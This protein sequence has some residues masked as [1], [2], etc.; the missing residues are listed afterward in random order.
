MLHHQGGLHVSKLGA[1]RRTGWKRDTNLS[2]V[3]VNEH[4]VVSGVEHKGERADDLV[5]RDWRGEGSV[6]SRTARLSPPKGPLAYFEQ[7]VPEGERKLVSIKECRCKAAKV[8]RVYLVARNSKLVESGPNREA[9]SQ[10]TLALG[11]SPDG[12]AILLDT[13]S[14]QELGIGLGVILEDES[15]VQRRERR[16]LP[17]TCR[18]PL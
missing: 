5:F 1:G 2:L 10:H 14:F 4:W 15:P 8:G 18:K 12:P 13:L 11:S 6:V 9:N 17:A 16:Q 3:A 7:K